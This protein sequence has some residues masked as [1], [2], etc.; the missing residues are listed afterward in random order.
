MDITNNTRHT[1]T[2]FGSCLRNIS[3]T[4][5]VNL[6]QINNL[7]CMIQSQLKDNDLPPTPLG[8]K[9]FLCCQKGTR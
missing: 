7:K 3:E 8:K 9:I 4:A 5:A 1:P 2:N 6:L